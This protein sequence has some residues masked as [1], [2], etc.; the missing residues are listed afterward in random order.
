VLEV[1]GQYTRAGKEKDNSTRLGWVSYVQPRNDGEQKGQSKSQGK[2]SLECHV[3][4][5]R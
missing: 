1:G 4:C 3:H 5:V 2:A